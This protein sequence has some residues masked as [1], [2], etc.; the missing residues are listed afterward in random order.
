VTIPG[1]PFT[2]REPIVFVGTSDLSGHFRGKS[3]PASDL[4]VKLQRGIGEAPTK[5]PGA[6]RR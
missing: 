6:V 3:W 4:P 5:A 2:Q 1:T